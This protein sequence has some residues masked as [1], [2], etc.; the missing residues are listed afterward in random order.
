MK[1]TDKSN[2]EN[3]LT[4][5]NM[6]TTERTKTQYDPMGNK[7]QFDSDKFIALV[8]EGKDYALIQYY[9]FGKY[10]K[11]YDQFFNTPYREGMIK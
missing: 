4:I 8:N 2:K 1:I 7:V 6:P 11:R 5:Y 3:T 10:F 9:V